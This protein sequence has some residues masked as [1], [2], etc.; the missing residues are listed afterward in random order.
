MKVMML[1][2]AIDNNTF[3]GGEYFNSSELKIADATIRDW[4]VNVGLTSGGTMTFLP[5]FCPLN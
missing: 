2:S 3:S 4:D 1:A 5:R